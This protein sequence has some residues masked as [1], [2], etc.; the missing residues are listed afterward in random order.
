MPAGQVAFFSVSCRLSVA[1]GASR[2]GPLPA[3]CGASPGADLAAPPLPGRS[4]HPTRTIEPV[5]IQRVRQMV[6]NPS[7]PSKQSRWGDRAVIDREACDDVTNPRSTASPPSLPR[8]ETT[9]THPSPP[10]RG[11]KPRKAGRWPIRPWFGGKNLG[12]AGGYGRMTG[13]SPRHP[14]WLAE[15]CC[16]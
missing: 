3:L 1:A 16:W 9:N 10:R 8:F 13:L 7:P 5:Q 6:G 15:L 12:S 4:K 14:A 2:V 11:L